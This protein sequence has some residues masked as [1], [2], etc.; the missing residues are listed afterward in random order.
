[1][2]VIDIVSRDFAK[3]LEKDGKLEQ[4]F[5][6]D[7]VNDAAMRESRKALLKKYTVVF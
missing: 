6:D 5:N 2:K 1:M 4:I 7:L 3:S